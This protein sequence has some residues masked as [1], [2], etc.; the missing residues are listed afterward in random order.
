[1]HVIQTPHC[2]D[3]V[4]NDAEHDG[5]A[6]EQE[7][8]SNFDTNH[9]A[10]N[11]SNTPAPGA[12][13]R[14]WDRK[15]VP[16]RPFQ[17]A[18][19]E[20]HDQ[21]ETAD[22]DNARDNVSALPA[23]R[24]WNQQGSGTPPSRMPTPEPE[25]E[26]VQHTPEPQMSQ[27]GVASKKRWWEQKSDGPASPPAAGQVDADHSEAEDMPQAP[28]QRTR[29]T[30]FSR[31]DAPAMPPPPRQSAFGRNDGPA[32][33]TRKSAKSQPIAPAHTP[34]AAPLAAD[35]ED[36]GEDFEMP[37]ARNSARRNQAPISFDEDEDANDFD[38][39]PERGER[40]SGGF[41][42]GLFARKAKPAPGRTAQVHDEDGEDE[43][44]DGAA[45]E[46][47]RAP[48]PRPAPA[49]PRMFGAKRSAQ[50][51]AVEDDD[52]NPPGMPL[53]RGYS[54]HDSKRG[55]NVPRPN[56]V[57]AQ[58]N[59]IAKPK[60]QVHKT[61]TMPEGPAKMAFDLD[62]SSKQQRKDIA[63]RKRRQSSRKVRGFMSRF[64]G[65]GIVATTC[66]ALLFTGI[67][68]IDLNGSFPLKLN[69]PEQIRPTVDKVSADAAPVVDAAKDK[70]GQ[71]AQ[72]VIAKVQEFFTVP[73]PTPS[74]KTNFAPAD[75]KI[76]P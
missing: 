10:E 75:T 18:A 69:L 63:A 62:D 37:P 31:E 32:Q 33:P 46:D 54:R 56:N 61:I 29:T 11:A 2:T 4:I 24:W 36:D 72:P 27:A 26:P 13:K 17:Q 55:P 47:E 6:P 57:F 67:V 42:G 19:P 20:P 3:D 49:R 60:K 21:N 50:P 66:V 64:A 53:P 34:K 65:I 74:P 70:L 51:I 39:T 9:A 30:A 41:L 25:S 35:E 8:M 12:N 43:D 16:Q 1:V 73:T 76:Q 44:E 14:W 28:P 52:A 40:K 23:K 15:D 5:Y 59:A 68:E 58:T 45:Y 48:E 71:Q 22:V 7:R 38:G